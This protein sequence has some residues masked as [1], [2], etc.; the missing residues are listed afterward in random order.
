MYLHCTCSIFVFKAMKC[1]YDKIVLPEF[2]NLTTLILD[3]CEFTLDTPTLLEYFLR[4]TPNLEKL[5]LQNCFFQ[6]CLLCV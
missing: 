1:N 3:E 5:T 6:K 4:H 2:H